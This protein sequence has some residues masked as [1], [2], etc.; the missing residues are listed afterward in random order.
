MLIY[1]EQLPID[2]IIPEFCELPF[3]TVKELKEHVLKVDVQYENPVMWYQ[4]DNDSDGTIGEKHK[5]LIVGI[6]TGHPHI[7][8]ESRKLLNMDSYIGTASLD[9]GSL[10]LHYFAIPKTDAEDND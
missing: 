5:Y 7:D 1:K 6:G 2:T 8:D 9:G 3:S 4:A 10:I